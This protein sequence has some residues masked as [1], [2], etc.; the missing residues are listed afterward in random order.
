MRATFKC[1]EISSYEFGGKRLAAEDQVTQGQTDR[2]IVNDAGQ[3]GWGAVEELYL[4]AS[5]V[6]PKLAGRFADRITDHHDRSA[7]NQRQRGLL[8]RGIETARRQKRCPEPG[9]TPK[10]A[11]KVESLFTRLACSTATPLGV[12]V[13]PDV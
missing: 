7:V 4:A 10:S 6:V 1:A 11:P 13:E 3:I 8:D 5:H 9:P 12:P 2:R